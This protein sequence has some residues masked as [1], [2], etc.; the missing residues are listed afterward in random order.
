MTA[1]VQ[2]HVD[3]H[4][5]TNDNAAY[6]CIRKPTPGY[7]KHDMHTAATPAY[8]AYLT[9]LA[10]SI[11]HPPPGVQSCYANSQP[12]LR[13]MHVLGAPS[14]A[15]VRIPRKHEKLRSVTA[16]IYLLGRPA[17]Q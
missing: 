12:L 3:T 15:P 4:M 11:N 17:V 16:T 9:G 10:N 8:L 2:G 1:A 14:Q 7:R 6:E 5:G 13:L